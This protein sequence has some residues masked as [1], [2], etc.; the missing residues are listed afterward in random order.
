MRHLFTRSGS[1]PS[2]PLNTLPPA[3]IPEKRA[4]VRS[5]T[6]LNGVAG[7]M[8]RRNH[9]SVMKGAANTRLERSWS[10]SPQSA[11]EVIYKNL[12]TLVARSRSEFLDGDYPKQ[13]VRM[14][15]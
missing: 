14:V 3:K 6:D 10:T 9:R 11:D 8:P 15:K 7:K 1:S 2:Q 4:G 13:F 5:L 12:R